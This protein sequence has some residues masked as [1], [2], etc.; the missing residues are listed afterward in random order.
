MSRLATLALTLLGAASLAACGDHQTTQPNNN[1]AKAKARGDNALEDAGE[2]GDL[3]KNADAV[4]VDEDSSFALF[5]AGMPD[6]DIPD[7]GLKEFSGN[8]CTEDGE[9]TKLF[10]I[11][12]PTKAY[13]GGDD[14]VALLKLADTI[15]DK[16]AKT[17]T[18]KVA[19]AVKL[20]VDA[21]TFF[22]QITT[23]MDDTGRARDLGIKIVDGVV[24]EETLQEFPG[25][26]EVHVKGWEKRSVLESKV[27]SQ[28]IRSEYQSR[29]DHWQLADGRAYL[30]SNYLTK[31]IKGVKGSA[32][33]AA[34][35]QDGDDTYLLAEIM[36][37]TDNRGV[38]SVA[39]DILVKLF[40]QG[41]KNMYE[42]GIKIKAL[43]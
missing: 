41:L 3:G 25:A 35:V 34:I 2:G 23:F 39:R 16:T 31:S 14:D 5:C 22:D 27:S 29:T 24:E 6:V 36:A 32:M 15:D 40:R 11:T 43:P 20:P 21:K 1:A 12:M 19:G 4:P 38:P 42:N 8:L 28:V 33:F 26:S 30:V 7:A 18:M 9:P 13:A 10:A 37:S 17:T